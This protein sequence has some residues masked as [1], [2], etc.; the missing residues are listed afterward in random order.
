MPFQTSGIPSVL[1]RQVMEGLKP[2]YDNSLGVQLGRRVPVD[3]I[4]GSVTVEPTI[5]SM[6]R[7]VDSGIAEGGVVKRLSG[8]LSELTYKTKVFK[9]TAEVPLGTEIQA[10]AV[11]YQILTSRLSTCLDTVNVKIDQ[12]FAETLEDTSLNTAYSI[13]NA[14]DDGG[15]ASDPFDDLRAMLDAVPGADCCILGYKVV[16]DLAQHPDFI[17]E[18]S[19]IAAGTLALPAVLDLIRTKLGIEKVE[20]FDVYYNGAAEGQ[21]FSLSRLFNRNVWLG[22][23]RDLPFMDVSTENPRSFSTFDEEAETTILGVS[24]RLV[25]KRPHQE[26]GQYAAN[27]VSAS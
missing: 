19:N 14:W 20:M 15:L 16:R 9:Q 17:A 2:K 11:G 13:T 8:E 5:T 25:F 18:S 23:S 12:H 27:A 26:L 24:R 4:S 3:A 22:Y 6:P 21:S 7:A 1:I 10:N